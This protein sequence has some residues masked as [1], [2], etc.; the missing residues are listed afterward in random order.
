MAAF[1]DGR[2]APPVILHPVTHTELIDDRITR[3]WAA[4]DEAAI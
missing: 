3:E 4:V 2:F 1:K